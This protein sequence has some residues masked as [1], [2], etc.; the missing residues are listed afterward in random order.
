MVDTLRI[1]R[2]DRAKRYGKFAPSMEGDAGFNLVCVEDTVIPP[3]KALAPTDIPVE[4][5]CKLP[6]GTFAKIEMR[7]G[8]YTRF[9]TLVL[10]NA[11]IDN[12]CT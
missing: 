8:T 5:R 1:V 3:G 4:I 10:F 2:T 12:G 7:S 6:D 9:P 11:P